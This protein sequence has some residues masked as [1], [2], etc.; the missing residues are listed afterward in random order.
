MTEAPEGIVGEL[1]VVRL[2][3]SGGIF[4]GGAA[5]RRSAASDVSS[6]WRCR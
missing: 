3:R 2:P 5:R 4:G 1:V 6:S